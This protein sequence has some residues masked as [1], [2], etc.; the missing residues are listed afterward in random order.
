MQA[1]GARPGPAVEI[2][3][4]TSASAIYEER[5][6]ERFDNRC[7][8]E[9]SVGETGNH[10]ARITP[11]DLLMARDGWSDE[12]RNHRNQRGRWVQDDVKPRDTRTSLLNTSSL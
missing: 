2:H 9:S 11:Y 10:L 6:Q 8:F 1:L 5:K 12:N 4:S 3:Y 7:C